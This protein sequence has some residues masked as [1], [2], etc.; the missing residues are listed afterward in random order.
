MNN[1]DFDENMIKEAVA[2]QDASALINKL[3][4]DDKKK[5]EAALSDKEALEALLK[6]PKAQALLKMFMKDK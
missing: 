5:L 3:S 2:K 1:R 6:T 4:N